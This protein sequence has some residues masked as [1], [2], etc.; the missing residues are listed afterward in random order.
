M[1]VSPA[2]AINSA[3]A[4]YRFNLPAFEQSVQLPVWVDGVEKVSKMKLQ[5]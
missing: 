1:L 2:G 5:N 4:I 3:D